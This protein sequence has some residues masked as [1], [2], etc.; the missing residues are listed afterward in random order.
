MTKLHTHSSAAHHAGL[1]EAARP[2]AGADACRHKCGRQDGLFHPA[3]EFCGGFELAPCASGGTCCLRMTSSVSVTAAEH[4][5]V[6]KRVARYARL[7]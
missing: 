6:R 7:R 5:S 1:F 2:P 3:C 4:H